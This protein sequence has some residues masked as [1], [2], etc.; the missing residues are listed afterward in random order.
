MAHIEWGDDHDP[1]EYLDEDEDNFIDDNEVDE[2]PFVLC[3][4]CQGKGTVWHSALA[5]WT[6]EDRFLD[7][8]GFQDMMD[9]VYD[10]P[11]PQCN[12]L[13]VVST[14]MRKE[15]VERVENQRLADHE[16]GDWGNHQY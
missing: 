8:D 9:G 15:Y 13:R 6:E 2:G 1:D 12:G 16:N 3:N 10:V 14:N 5:V 7:P 4:R 11:C